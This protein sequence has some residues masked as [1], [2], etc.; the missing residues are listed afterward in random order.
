[1]S[2]ASNFVG[3]L[4]AS[5]MLCQATLAQASNHVLQLGGGVM[6]V[7]HADVQYAPSTARALTAEFWVRLTGATNGGRPIAKRGCSSS[8][9]TI[10]LWP[11]GQL[12][13]E[14][15]GVGDS[16][17]PTIPLDEWHHCAVVW[18][19]L[20]AT[21]DFIVDGVLATRVSVPADSNLALGADSLRFGETCGLSISGAMDNIRIWSTA[22]T[23]AQILANMSV[24]FTPQQAAQQEGLV[25]SWSFEGADQFADAT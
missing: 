8:G 23:A 12:R 6:D 7:P 14:L 13:A 2:N 25:G 5:A 18:S 4:L 16:P 21:L 20:A 11:S 24:Q 10:Q 9:I 17:G 22:R 19:G 15:G 1:M 3:C